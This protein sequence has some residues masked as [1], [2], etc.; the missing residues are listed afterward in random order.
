MPRLGS[1]IISTTRP[2]QSPP[3]LRLEAMRL[4]LP[5]CLPTVTNNYLNLPLMCN[6]NQ[7]CGPRLCVSKDLATV[8]PLNSNTV[9]LTSRPLRSARPPSSN[10]DI[11]ALSG[12]MTIPDL[13]PY[14]ESQHQAILAQQYHIL[15]ITIPHF[16]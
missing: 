6:I 13:Y 3:F 10:C 16:C 14:P 1:S 11:K 8:L 7:H 2:K 12:M 9:S 15:L 4:L 5:L